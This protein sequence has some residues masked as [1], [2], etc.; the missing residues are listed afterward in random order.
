MDGAT[1]TVLSRALIL[2]YMCLV[3]VAT[4]TAVR[5]LL[6]RRCTE[7]RLLVVLPLLMTSTHGICP[8]LPLWTPSFIPLPSLLM[9][10]WT[11]SWESRLCIWQVQL[12]HPLDIGSTVI[13]LG[14]SYRGKR[15][16]ARLT[17]IVAKCLNELNGVWRIT[18]GC[19]PAPLLVAHL[20]PNCM[21]RPQLIRTALSR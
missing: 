6:F 14:A 18:M 7:M 17:S 10:V 15:F 8:S 4:A 5:L 21:G 9:K 12:P 2:W 13:R 11:V 3:K 1:P 20:R 19:R 16:V